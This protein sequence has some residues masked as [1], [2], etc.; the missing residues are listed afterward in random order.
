MNQ[1]AS[2]MVA[3]FSKFNITQAFAEQST[4]QKTCVRFKSPYPERN[5]ELGFFAER[6][7]GLIFVIGAQ[8]PSMTLM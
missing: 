2:S 5:P 3:K 4:R 8:K 7:L 6:V 1:S